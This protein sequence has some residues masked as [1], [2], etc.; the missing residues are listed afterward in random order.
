MYATRCP[1]GRIY[2]RIVSIEEPIEFVIGTEGL[3]V[4]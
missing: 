2:E 3:W 4:L 1:I